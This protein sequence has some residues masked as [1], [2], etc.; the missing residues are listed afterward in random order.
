MINFQSLHS[1]PVFLT[2]DPTCTAAV[3][4]YLGINPVGDVSCAV[5]V[6][7]HPVLHGLRSRP[8]E[9]G[10]IG[11][12]GIMVSALKQ[13]AVEGKNQLELYTEIYIY[14]VYIYICIYV[15][16]YLLFDFIDEQQSC[17][18]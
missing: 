8:L 2:E 11:K 18:F 12:E 7:L 15:H 3:F 13:R 4:V 10:G 14:Y 16:I 5:S 6:Y 9:L 17:V 1:E